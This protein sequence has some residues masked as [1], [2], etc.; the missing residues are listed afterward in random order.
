MPMYPHDYDDDNP[1]SKLYDKLGYN[2]PKKRP[3]P[4]Q[5]QRPTYPRGYAL[6]VYSAAPLRACRY[7]KM[8]WQ[9]PQE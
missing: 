6:Y 5:A 7:L 2:R 9:Y 1:F 3:T 8:S 4:R